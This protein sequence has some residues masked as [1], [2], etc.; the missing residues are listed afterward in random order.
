MRQWTV[1]VLFGAAGL[2]AGVAL[3]SVERSVAQ[4]VPASQNMR[5]ILSGASE[6]SMFMVE[7][8][9]GET[10]TLCPPGAETKTLRHWMPLE[11]GK[12]G[13]QPPGGPWRT[14]R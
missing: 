4:P 10:W 2:L 12:P 11:R 1:G 13:P 7:T 5:Y 8:W 9:T 14:G 3:G 6:G